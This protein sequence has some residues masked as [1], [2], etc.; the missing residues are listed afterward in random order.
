MSQNDFIKLKH[1]NTS[2]ASKNFVKL[3]EDNKTYFLN[4]KWGS[5]K[6]EF[7]EEAERY[8]KKKFVIVDFWKLND[9]RTTIEIAFAK[10]HPNYYWG[11]RCL[12]V[13]LVAISILMTNVVNLGLSQIFP[14][15]IVKF[16]GVLALFVAVYQFFKAKTDGFYSSLLTSKYVS[17][18]NKILVIDDFD[19]LSEK[20]TGRSLQII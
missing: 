2:A 19:R 17:L 14:N 20:T 5:G 6:T 12:M 7:L 10:L 1:I 11:I 9:S 18:S 3:L 8:T 16:A 4:G 13:F 15:W